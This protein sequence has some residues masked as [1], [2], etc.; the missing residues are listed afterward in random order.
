VGRLAGPE[1]IAERDVLPTSEAAPSADV[2]ENTGSMTR[3][4]AP[5]RQ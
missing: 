2:P 5:E 4:V 3:R 1:L